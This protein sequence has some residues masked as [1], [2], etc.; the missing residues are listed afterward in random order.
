M[1]TAAELE[2]RLEKLENKMIYNYIDTNTAKIAP[3]ANDALNAAIKK[4][5]LAG[6]GDGLNLTED[7]VKMHISFYRLGLYNWLVYLNEDF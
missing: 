5:I 6:N 1:A 4:G 7:L 2:A 3:D